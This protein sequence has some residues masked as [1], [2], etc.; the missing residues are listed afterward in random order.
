VRSLGF[1][2]VRFPRESLRD[3]L[4]AVFSKLG[5]NCVLDVGAHHGAFVEIVRDAGFDGFV[6]SFEPVEESFA[7]LAAA[8]ERDPAWQ[9]HRLALGRESG[10]AAMNVARDARFSSFRRGSQYAGEFFRESLPEDRQDVQVAR[11]DAIFDEV[12]PLAEPRAFLKL[13]TQGWDLDVLEGATAC[14]HSIWA[15]QC[16]VAVKPLYADAPT[17]LDAL[18]RM[19]ELGFELSGIFPVARDAELRIVELDCVLVRV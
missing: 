8:S 4:Q 14:L 6:A 11:L 9:V 18:P 17:Y 3:H 19:T 16:E 12:V 7:H 5:I 13:D 2:V 15:I 10:S 1:D